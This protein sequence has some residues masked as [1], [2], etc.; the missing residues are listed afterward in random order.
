MN[1]YPFIHSIHCLSAF[2]KMSCEGSR[3]S[4]VLQTFFSKHFLAPPRGCQGISRSDEIFH[5]SSEFWVYPRVSSQLGPRKPP[6]GGTLQ[7]PWSDAR[8]TSTGSRVHDRW[9]RLECGCSGKLRVL[10][11]SSAPS[12]PWWSSTTPSLLNHLSHSHE[13]KS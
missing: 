13:F 12:S 3:L 11:F 1:F 8:A 4:K 9:R 7:A 10:P 2:P 5:P 6:K